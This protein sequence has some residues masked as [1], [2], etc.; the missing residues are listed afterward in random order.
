MP[1]LPTQ[2]TTTIPESARAAPFTGTDNVPT[3]LRLRRATAPSR[4]QKPRQPVVAMQ[5]NSRSVLFCH[6]E[7]AELGLHRSSHLSPPDVLGDH[8]RLLAAVL[9]HILNQVQ[10]LRTQPEASSVRLGDLERSRGT[11][12][13]CCC[14]IPTAEQSRRRLREKLVPAG[15]IVAQLPF[16]SEPNQPLRHVCPSSHL[17]IQHLRPQCR[18]SDLEHLGVAR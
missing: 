17:F 9:L 12:A 8:Q 5:R 13:G 16:M 10:H 2:T 6:L 4:K 7:K 18:H 14:A 1:F 11:A 3:Y 15:G